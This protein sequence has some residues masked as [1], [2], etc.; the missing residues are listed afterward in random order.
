M[1]GKKTVLYKTAYRDLNWIGK[2]RD[3]FTRQ[4]LCV[5]RHERWIGISQVWCRGESTPDRKNSICKTFWGQK[6]PATLEEWEDGATGSSWKIRLERP[7]H[8]GPRRPRQRAYSTP[9]VPVPIVNDRG[10][11][12]NILFS[13]QWFSDTGDLGQ[14]QEQSAGE[15][16]SHLSRRPAAPEKGLGHS[17]TAEDIEQFLLNYLKEKDVADGN[18][19][20]FDNEEGNYLFWLSQFF[21]YEAD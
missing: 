17:T 14:P 21:L 11:R 5:L 10:D 19:S 1:K 3:G 13:A 2:S 16:G 9:R 4:V 8:V 20:D 6:T 18:V 12:Y 7:D 15:E